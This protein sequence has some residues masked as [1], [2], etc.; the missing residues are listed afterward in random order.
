MHRCF[1]ILVL[2]LMAAGLFFGGCGPQDTLLTCAAPDNCESGGSC[3]IMGSW[4]VSGTCRQDQG[5]EVTVHYT[6]LNASEEVMHYVQLYSELDVDGFEASEVNP[7][8]A[9]HQSE[10]G[11]SEFFVEFETIQPNESVTAGYTAT[12][13]VSGSEGRFP[14]A[15]ACVPGVAMRTITFSPF[16]CN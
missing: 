9:L 12:W 5:M 14:S 7:P 1:L 13:N 8:D 2:L 11:K 10:D 6:L 16:D 4:G 15:I 3:P